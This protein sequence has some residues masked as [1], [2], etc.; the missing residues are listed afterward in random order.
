DN[1]GAVTTSYFYRKDAATNFYYEYAF[2]DDYSVITFD[3][4]IE[5]EI[6]ILKENLATNDTWTSATWTG[7]DLSDSV[8]KKLRYTFTCT[9][10]NA[11]VTL[12]SKTY[13]NV[14][15]VTMKSQTAPAASST[16]TD[17]GLIW[18]YWYA[19]GIGL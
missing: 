10:A 13:N 7:T 2:V 4:S 18:E 16:F 14:Y 8:S 17:E 1:S 12:G 3:S 15:K 19:K 11:T 9:N 5:G 6:L